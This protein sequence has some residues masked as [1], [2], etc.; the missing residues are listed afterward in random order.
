[1]SIKKIHLK[2]KIQPNYTYKHLN[3]FLNMIILG[4]ESWEWG[5]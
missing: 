4:Y 5:F 2:Y 3:Y 1:M